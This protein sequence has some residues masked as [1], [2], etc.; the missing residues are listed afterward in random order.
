[1]QYKMLL[2]LSHF[3]LLVIS[4]LS[5]NAAPLDRSGIQWYPYLEWSLENHTYKGNPFDVQAT[6]SFTHSSGATRTTGM[7]YDGDDTWKFRFTGTKTGEWTFKTN[8]PEDEL[9]GKTGTVTINPNPDPQ[10]HGFI[11]HF[12]PKWGWEGTNSAFVPQLVM[13][14]D[15]TAFYNKPDKIEN[16]IQTFFVEHGFNGFHT[17]VLC[18]WFDF[19]VTRYDD[20]KSDDPN[21]DPRTFEAL[22]L[23]I[24]KAHRAGGMVHLWAWGDQQRHMTPNKWGKNGKV[25]RRLQRYIAARLGPLPGWSMGYGFDLFEW[26]DSDDLRQWHDYMH[27]Q[28]GWHHFLGG[29]SG[30]PRSG[31]DH[32]DQQ[33]HEGLDYSAY[34]HHRPTY[35]VYVAAIMARPD[36][37]SFS[38][39]R[40]RIRKPSPY[41]KKDYTEK[42]TRRGLWHSTLAGGVANIWGNLVGGSKHGGSAPYPHPHWIKTYSSFFEHRFLKNMVRENRI[43]DGVCLKTPDH[44]R[45][46]VY[47]EDTDSIT[48]DLTKMKSAKSACVVDTQK[49]HR[50]IDLGKLE[51]KQHSWK[52]PY[53]SD[54]ALAIGDFQ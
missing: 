46:V 39:D 4:V 34:E 2:L 32:S 24:T 21:P 26:V 42:L 37:P 49:P 31:T 17:S 8:S 15:P 41:P 45:F 5:L 9:N 3:L 50:E 16:D 30:G 29:R 23:L 43:T 6:V 40:F 44:T 13:Y 47:K 53:K 54:W 35:E 10:A 11:T 48:I 25:D 33:I 22:E 7:F 28:F 12:G 52:A 14:D 36:K 38:E 19:D 51:P 20:I 27:E 18:R 1:M